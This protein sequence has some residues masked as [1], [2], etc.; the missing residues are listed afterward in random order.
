MGS[1]VS[2]TPVLTLEQVVSPSSLFLNKGE[3]IVNT[4]Q[5]DEIAEA[6]STLSRDSHLSETLDIF[7]GKLKPKLSKELDEW[8]S[9]STRSNREMRASSAASSLWVSLYKKIYVHSNTF[10]MKVKNEEKLMQ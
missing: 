1:P 6:G 4:T 7:N 2:D 10:E 9:F 5:Y 8:L 3:Q